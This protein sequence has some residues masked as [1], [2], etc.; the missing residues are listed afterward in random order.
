MGVHPRLEDQVT[1]GEG[2]EPFEEVC[3]REQP[4]GVGPAAHLGVGMPRCHAPDAADQPT[5][6]Q[7]H[8]QQLGEVG[9]PRVT[10]G[11]HRT[12]LRSA[13][14][15]ERQTGDPACLGSGSH[16]I[17]RA[18]VGLHVHHGLHRNTGQ[19]HHLGSIGVVVLGQI[20]PGDELGVE[21]EFAVALGNGI[22][23]DGLAQYRRRPVDAGALC[24]LTRGPERVPLVNVRV[25][26]AGDD[27]QECPTGQTRIPFG[28]RRVLCPSFCHGM[29]VPS[30]V[31]TL[32]ASS[33]PIATVHSCAERGTIKYGLS[34]KYLC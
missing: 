24:R 7:M 28:S 21:H 27:P 33:R 18:P 13:F 26:D 9:A 16:R 29:T 23:E 8:V 2:A 19:R 22:P 17:V 25:D 6:L 1:V 32:I 5:D 34:R 20:R 31:R 14:L 30:V 4:V 12:Q 10:S 11:D 15:T 3:R